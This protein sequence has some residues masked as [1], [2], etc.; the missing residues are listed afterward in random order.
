MAITMEL[1]LVTKGPICETT[2]YMVTTGIVK[3]AHSQLTCDLLKSFHTDSAI[4]MGTGNDKPTTQ[5][6][7]R[8]WQQERHPTTQKF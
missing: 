6:R 2:C 1:A 8:G 5:W 4:N 3:T 7:H